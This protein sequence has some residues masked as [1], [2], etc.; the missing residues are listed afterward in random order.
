MLFGRDVSE[1]LLIIPPLLFSLTVHEFSHALAAWLLGDQTAK[2][3]GRL[4]LNPVRHLD[5][6]GT[7]L[8][9]MSFFIGWAKPVPVN[10]R[11]FKSPGRDMAIV[12]AAGPAANLL[13]VLSAAA[14]L[15]L[16]VSGNFF[17]IL[18]ESISTPLGRMLYLSFFL[19]IGLCFF[20]L[21]PIP[22]LDGFGVMRIILPV[23]ARYFLDNNRLLFFLAIVILVWSGV[24][25]KILQPIFELFAD[26][27]LPRELRG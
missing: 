3:Q 23:K 25:F 2:D 11:N 9:L 10:P 7:L 5:P 22:P 13:L 18:P 27:L 20:N 17:L 24:V 12:S 16:A 14:L 26:N 1:Y 21:I 15:H 19:N 8:I 4:S 6:L